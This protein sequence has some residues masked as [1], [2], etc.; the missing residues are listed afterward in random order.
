MTKKF[1]GFKRDAMEKKI[2]PA[3]G[4]TGSMDQK[5]INAFLA[6]NPR[7]AAKMGKYT[8]AARQRIE[9]TKGM[10]E[11]GVVESAVAPFPSVND[12]EPAKAT[13]FEIPGMDAQIPLQGEGVSIP[14]PAMPALEERNP[15]LVDFDLKTADVVSK[16]DTLSQA[17]QVLANAPTDEAAK[18]AMEDAQL[19]LTQA[20]AAASSAGNSLQDLTN[21]TGTT[22]K[23]ILDPG[24]LV[25]KAEVDTIS[26]TDKAAGT[27]AAGTGEMGPVTEA[28][29]T[30]AEAVADVEAP[31]DMTANTYD[32]T[33]VSAD[34]KTTLEKLS[35]ATGKPSDEALADAATMKPGDLAALGLTV[36]QI[37]EARKVV[38]PAARKIEDGELISGSTVDMDRVKKETNFEAATGAPSSDATVQGQLTGLMEQFEGNEPPSWA[39]GA[40]RAAASQ[41]AARGLSASSMAG[42]AAIQAAM[43][44]AMPIAVQDSQTAA[45]F[46]MQ[47]LSN[48]QQSAMFAA[49]KRAEFLGLE[50]TQE[51]QSRV[52]NAAKIS[53]I[54]NMNFTADVQI[55]LEN[56]RMA[57]S[58]DITNLN[59]TN[60]KIMADAAAM[61]NVDMTNLNNRQQ[62]AVQTANAFLNMDMKNLDNEQQTATFKTQALVNTM[63]SDQAAANASAQFNATSQNQTDQFFA[64]LSNSVAQFNNEQANAM[65]RFNAGETNALSQFNALQNNAADQFNAK[66]QLVVA[67][68]NAQWFQNITTTEN[69]ANNQANRDEVL[70][71][72]NLTMTAYNNIVQRER[73]LLSW[74]WQS[75]ENAQSRDADILAAKISAEASVSAAEANKA[76]TEDGFSKASGEFLTKLA[77]SAAEQFF[78]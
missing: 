45:S 65:S 62:A 7:A 46:E 59:A 63:L 23:A 21:P 19:A 1:A 34:V 4:Y 28:T 77:V 76:E 11:G 68:A 39:A 74:A 43:E 40:M 52:T 67:Q 58:V 72:N 70:A 44:S 71:S 61:T 15:A 42:Q 9:G 49:E 48:R 56:A 24:S 36:E 20:Q 41:M 32:A 33:T 51:F 37:A 55:A 14:L 78:K 66:N 6:A 38:A 54:A 3:L 2:L 13:T 30:T 35:A 16:R 26:E 18:K 73:D 75:A 5:M 8:L 10:A 29:G 60:A 22:A 64:N 12:I 47:N 27:I 57:Q 25:S 31:A 69:A 17:R 53:D 50:F